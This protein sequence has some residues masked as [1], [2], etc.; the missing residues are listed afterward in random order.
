MLKHLLF[1]NIGLVALPV[2][3]VLGVCYVCLR[4]AVILYNK[5][6]FVDYRAYP[7]TFVIAEPILKHKLYLPFKRSYPWIGLKLKIIPVLPLGIKLLAIYYNL[8]VAVFRW[9]RRPRMALPYLHNQ[10]S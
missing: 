6:S 2:I 5:V 1:E 3:F 8:D 9:F 4:I 7:L 10:T